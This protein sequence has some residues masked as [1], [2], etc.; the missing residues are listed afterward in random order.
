VNAYLCLVLSN[1]PQVVWASKS[2]KALLG[3]EVADL[4]ASHPALTELI[5]P[6]DADI[7]ERFFSASADSPA[8]EGSLRIRRAD[9][10][11]RC[12]YASYRREAIR[13]CEAI[14]H[15]TLADAKGL[16]WSPAEALSIVDSAS[17][18]ALEAAAECVHIKDRNHVIALANTKYRR[19]VSGSTGAL[20]EVAG[21]TDY[22][23]FPEQIADQLY[24]L[25]K[26]ILAGSLTEHLVQER[27]DARG[28]RRWLDIRKSPMR[29]KNG[30]I[31]GILTTT[32]D[33][34]DRA[35]AEHPT[36][37]SEKLRQ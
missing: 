13:Q 32:T 35:G 19:L 37:E 27:T 4:K 20:K 21:L 11:I 26:Q 14:L 3:H 15:L 10:H 33:I 2:V 12:M 24:E 34:T 30:E 6:G 36:R 18:G 22:D 9:G 28:T 7:A 23:L 16:T 25:D 31:V 8:G 1:R 17:A 5:H 29:G